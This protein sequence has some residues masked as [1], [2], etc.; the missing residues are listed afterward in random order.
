MVE[1]YTTPQRVTDVVPVPPFAMGNVPDTFD[2][3]AILP[4]S[5]AVPTPL[6]INAFPAATAANLDK[7]EVED[8]YNISPIV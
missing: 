1:P 2:A 3:N 5:G 6:D 4:H 8:A 7:A